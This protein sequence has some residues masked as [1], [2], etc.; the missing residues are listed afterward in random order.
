M[1][2]FGFLYIICEF[3]AHKGNFVSVEGVILAGVVCSTI[4]TIPAQIFPGA[5]NNN[6]CLEFY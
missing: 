2:V 5:K 4:K 1:L 6:S 3:A